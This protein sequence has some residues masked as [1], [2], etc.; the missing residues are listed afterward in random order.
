M[1][2]AVR[3]KMQQVKTSKTTTLHV[4]RTFLYISLMSLHN[5]EVNCLIS[6]FINHMCIGGQISLSVTSHFPSPL[7]RQEVL[8]VL[9]FPLFHEEIL[10]IEVHGKYPGPGLAVSDSLIMDTGSGVP[11]IYMVRPVIKLMVCGIYHWES[12]RNGRSNC[13]I[14]SHFEAVSLK[15]LDTWITVALRTTNRHML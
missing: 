11:N 8:L 9:N 1:V 14:P 13:R 15:E 10:I 4:Q 2:I 6:H 5:Y 12:F 7:N 3:T